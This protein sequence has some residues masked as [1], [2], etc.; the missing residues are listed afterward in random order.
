LK[1]KYLDFFSVLSGNAIAQAIMFLCIILI[2]RILSVED[3]GVFTLI[4]SLMVILIQ[5]SDFGTSSSYVKYL[6][7]EIKN[8]REIFI[9]ALVS[10]LV[11]SLIIVLFAVNFIDSALIYL[12]DSN[13]WNEVVYI[14]LGAIFSQSLLN[15]IISHL[16]ALQRFR[17]Y[18]FILIS[19]SLIRLIGIS[20]L[21]LGI[22]GG[23]II[24]QFIFVYFYSATV[25]VVYIFLSKIK[26]IRYIFSFN[27]NHFKEIY[28]VGLWIF[29]SSLIVLG[30]LKLDL[31]MLKVLGSNNAVAIFS[32]ALT[33]NSVLSLLVLSLSNTLLPKINSFLKISSLEKY[34]AIAFSYKY[35]VLAFSI[36]FTILTPYLV[37][38][39][40]GNNYVSSSVPL[41]ILVLSFF[42]SIYASIFFPVMLEKNKAHVLTL[43]NLIQ[44]T[45]V[46]A[47][48]LILIP[49]FQE[50]GAAISISIMRIF[51]F[52]F[53]MVY[54]KKNLI[55]EA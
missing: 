16:Q 7:K 14:S 22:I 45:I 47:L 17:M 12:F 34:I 43:M 55:N 19:H 28:S 10:K 48:N 54:V 44:L 38:L 26:E 27:W 51:G 33:F 36:I 41:Q 1:L 53:L 2:S 8:A 4:V 3:Y 37:V 50:V 42:F 18:S 49:S 13:K 5:V 25:I 11:L 40:F 35:Y 39:A 46:F 15:L 24:E 32:V 29:L 9:T 21:A 31:F 52:F 23:V 30:I 6:S 20:L